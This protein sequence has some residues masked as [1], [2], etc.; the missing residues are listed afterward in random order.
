[1]YNTYFKVK[2]HDIE[3]E[4]ILKLTN[5]T[6]VEPE[7][8]TEVESEVNEYSS[9][10]IS[11]VCYKL[12]IDELCSVFYAENIIDNKIDQ[13]MKTVFAKMIINSDF[14][15]IIDQTKSLLSFN[16][17]PILTEDQK[18]NLNDNSE[19]I[20][21]L[22]L[23]SRSV[24]YITHKCICQQLAIGLIDNELLDELKKHTIRVLTN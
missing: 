11:D 14:K 18:T 13:G 2:Y 6:D 15:S 21:I 1:M 24:F 12:Y 19:F 10:D 17:S 8:K 16:E 3:Q 23:F 4:L 7:V 20:I 5:K 22:T 9:Q